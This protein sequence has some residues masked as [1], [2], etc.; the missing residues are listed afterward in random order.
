MSSFTTGMFD[1]FNLPSYYEIIYLPVLYLLRKDF[2]FLRPIGK[3]FRSLAFVWFI[4]LILAVILG[5]FSTGGIL[6]V[7][8]S[9][10]L[11]ILFVCI[12]M[13]I[14]M[15]KR[16]YTALFLLSLGS[17]IGW[18]LY[19]QGK[20]MGF[21]PWGENDLL[22]AFYGNML[23][24]PVGISIVFSFF[25]N[26]FLILIVL[27]VNVFLSFTSGLRRQMLTSIISFV[28]YYAVYF[29]RGAKMKTLIPVIFVV[30]GIISALPLIE[31]KVEEVSPYLHHRVFVRSADSGENEGDVSRQNHVR[32]LFDEAENLI[33]PHGFVSKRTS[34]DRGTGVFVDMPIYE[35]SYT[36]GMPV[37]LILYVFLIVR[38]IKIFL[39]Y[40]R[41]RTPPLSVWF[42]CGTVF[43]M[44]LLLDG[45]MLSWTYVVPFTG[46]IL[47]AIIRYGDNIRVREIEY[48]ND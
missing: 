44:L 9:Y 12:G 40:M 2:S 27:G 48:Y 19:I 32:M 5:S 16:F 30:V 36:F 11:I 39:I 46:I 7:A 3:Q 41:Y 47:G 37:A 34:V 28:M 24:I 22:F 14:K 29:L 6:S 13:N 20:L 17:I 25:P 23:S 8:R 45:S 1:K 18:V 43:V 15:D 33:L 4:L 38:V 31:D 10:L 42:I 35:L 26:I 21:F